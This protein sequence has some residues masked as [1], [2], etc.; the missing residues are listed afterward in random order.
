MAPRAKGCLPGGG[1]Q[2][3]G[4]GDPAAPDTTPAERARCFIAAVQDRTAAY[5]WPPAA[6]ALAEGRMPRL[7]RAGWR[8]FYQHRDECRTAVDLRAVEAEL[9]RLDALAA[10]S[11]APPPSEGLTIKA[12]AAWF[13]VD[14]RTLSKHLVKVP[15]GP[16]R[17]LAPGEVPARR[18]GDKLRIF[19]ADFRGLGLDGGNDAAHS[20]PAANTA[21][22]TAIGRQVD[23]V[24]R[25]G[26]DGG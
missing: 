12:A 4:A 18:I 11:S 17:P 22:G 8:L 21:K 14:R 19:I 1:A 6:A 13:G 5:S 23:R 10:P 15:P 9:G 24:L 2:R 25:R 7:T 16:L 3:A 20:A 26:T